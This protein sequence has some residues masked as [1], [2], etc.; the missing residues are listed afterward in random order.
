MTREDVPASSARL[1]LAHGVPLLHPKTQLSEAMLEGWRNQMLARNLAPQR[2]EPDP[3]G[4]SVSRPCERLSVAVVVVDGRWPMA[5]LRSVR[6]VSVSTVRAYQTDLTVTGAPSLADTTS[7][8][9]ERG[10]LELQR[11][12][13]L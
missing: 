11:L 13:V 2:S 9:L 6:H 7:V 12:R 4:A 3:S 8:V 10:L 1:V 5:D